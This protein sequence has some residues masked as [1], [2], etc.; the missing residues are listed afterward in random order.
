[1]GPWHVPDGT[2][3]R[4]LRRNPARLARGGYPRI[5]EGGGDYFVRTN[6]YGTAYSHSRVVQGHKRTFINMLHAHV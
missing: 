1:M 3:E 4:V 2:C 5:V 6:A